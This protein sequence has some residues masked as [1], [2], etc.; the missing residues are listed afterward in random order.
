MSHLKLVVPNTPRKRKLPPPADTQRP[1]P[2]PEFLA[3]RVLALPLGEQ[4]I[5]ATLAELADP[6]RHEKPNSLY[7]LSD[8]QNRLML[9]GIWPMHP[10]ID[11]PMPIHGMVVYPAKLVKRYPELKRVLDQLDGLILLPPTA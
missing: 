9:V 4:T 10:D 3:R 2:T 1:V 6:L 8:L 11:D 7:R 5:G